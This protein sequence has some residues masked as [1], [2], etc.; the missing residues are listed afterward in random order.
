MLHHGRITQTHSYPSISQRSKRLPL[1]SLLALST[2]G[3]LTTMLEAIPAGILPALRSGMG[4]TETAAGQTVTVYA[5]G[6]LTGAIP[7]IG[8]SMGW[9]RR[10]L[11]AIALAGYVVTSLVVAISPAFALTLIACFAPG[12]F[13][14]VL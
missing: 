11:L 9:P 10:R 12:I 6:S 13:A 1:G 14:G 5:I 3:F 4:V 2:A 8:A 7:I